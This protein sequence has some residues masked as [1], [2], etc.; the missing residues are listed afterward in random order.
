MPFTR[1]AWHDPE[2]ELSA[3]EYRLVCLIDLNE[4]GER[5]VKSK[6]KLPVKSRPN[7]PYNIHAMHAAAAALAGARNPVNAPAEAKRKAARKLI[8]LYKEA[9]DEPPES[10]Y[11]IAGIP[12]P[13]RS[14]K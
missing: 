10:L 11:R 5:P 9:G 1:E 4:P 6:C 14:E 3:E 8:A 12:I 7:A 13:R 2:S